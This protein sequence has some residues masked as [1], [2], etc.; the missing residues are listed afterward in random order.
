MVE[1]LSI[2]PKFRPEL[3]P[4]FLPAVLW[5]RAY[6]ELV[7]VEG[8]GQ[9]V[10][11]ALQ[12]ED[13]TTFVHE[14]NVL[15]H[16]G[17]N[18][19]LNNLYLERLL[20][21]LLWQKG[22]PTVFIAADP[23]IVAY[24]RHAYSPNGERA[25][26]YDFFST[27]AF[28]QPLV[29]EHRD[30]QA[31]PSARH[32]NRP[33]GRHFEG[34]RVGFDLG[35]SDRKCAAVIDGKVIFTAEVPWNPYFQ[36]DPRY[37]IE[38]INDSIARA[39]AKLPRVDAI[40]GSAAGIYVNNEVR[41]GS[42]Y[43]GLSREDFDRH[44]RRLFFVLKERWNNV[45]FEVVNDGEVT[46][47]AG[48]MAFNVNSVLGIS[49]GT[50][51]AAGYVTPEGNITPWFNELAFVP[52]DYRREAPVDEW[53]GDAG[54]GSQYFS[55]QAVGRLLEPAGISLPREM[56]LP[57]KLGEVQKMMARGDERARRIYLTI[58]TYLGYAIAQFADF[59]Q[60]ENVLVL[61]RVMS[62]EGGAVIVERANTVLAGEFP[63]LHERIR[64]HMPDE[65]FKR[66][67]Q[68]VAAASLPRLVST[69]GGSAR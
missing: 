27:Q 44:I 10:V 21:F 25:F 53:S 20:K 26:D 63:D 64:I 14:T 46:A 43:R 18:A 16:E 34:C 12:R 39:A 13:G 11:I 68:A 33:L 24:L 37:H 57:E 60:I 47:L 50:S 36:K 65:A 3:D 69:T 5:V 1:K 41:V 45:P 42:L 22:A 52:V 6:Q 7:K 51:T 29:I 66:L 49:M 15:I 56:P 67:G 8:K 61:G 23:R 55:Q 48:S 31:M 38:G 59:Y 17:E 32:L 9:R 2:A 19:E 62:G 28:V 40:G 58:G 30:P 54:C 35:G 4:D